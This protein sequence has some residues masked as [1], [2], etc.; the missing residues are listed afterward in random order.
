MDPSS[1]TLGLIFLGVMAATDILILAAYIG[2][3][4]WEHRLIRERRA[5]EWRDY[6]PEKQGKD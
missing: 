6:K 4:V 2:R 1:V 5:R 3:T